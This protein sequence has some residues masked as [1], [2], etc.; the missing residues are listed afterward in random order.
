MGW[1]S[2]AACRTADPALFF[3][4]S[5]SSSESVAMALEYCAACPAR[6]ACLTDAMQYSAADDHGIAGGLTRPKRM[7]LR[8]LPEKTCRLEGC[9]NPRYEHSARCHSHY[10]EAKRDWG[11]ARRE[12]ERASR[13]VKPVVSRVCEAD[14]CSDPHLAKGLCKIHYGRKYMADRRAR[15]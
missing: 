9:D 14:G 1:R 6:D 3:P 15:R 7:G 5:R 2:E 10:L 8:G 13:P 4:D 11:R 12:A